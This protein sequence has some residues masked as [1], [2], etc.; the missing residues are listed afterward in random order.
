MELTKLFMTCRF[1]DSRKQMDSSQVKPREVVIERKKDANSKAM[2][3]RIVDSTQ[4]LDVDE[5]DNIVCVFTQGAEW[6]FKNWQWKSPDE[7]F[8]HCKQSFI[9]S[10]QNVKTLLGFE[11]S[12]IIY[13]S[14]GLGI[15]PKFPDENLRDNVRSWNIELL[16]VRYSWDIAIYIVSKHL[17]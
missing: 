5:W 2:R 7:I 17:L 12:L 16:N 15:Y 9:T 1:T 13:L 4:N 3:Y 6:Q 11:F 8:R 10:L 14:L